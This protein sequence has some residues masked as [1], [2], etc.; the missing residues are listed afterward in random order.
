MRLSAYLM[1]IVILLIG[2]YNFWSLSFLGL[3]GN[4][5]LP[6]LIFFGAFSVLTFLVQRLL[7]SSGWRLMRAWRY[8]LAFLTSVGIGVF[9]WFFP[10]VGG[11]K[12]NHLGFLAS[13]LG[14]SFAGAMLVTALDF[15]LW[16][17]NAPPT[18]EIEEEV[19][20]GHQEL[21]GSTLPEP[22]MK[23]VFDII[24]SLIVLIACFPIWLAIIFI[25]W[26]ED[27]G[28]IIFIKNCVG[29]GGVNFLQ[30]KFR[31]MVLNAEKKTGPV[32]GTID[33]KRA[34]LTGKA[35]R[36]L[37]LDELPQVINI[38]R[39][40][41]SF[42]GPRPQRTVLVWGYLQRHPKYALRHQVRP[43][44]AGLQVVTKHC[45][46]PLQRLRLDRVYVCHMSIRFDMRILLGAFLVVLWLRWQKSWNGCLPDWLL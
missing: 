20:Q 9:F 14:G 10:Q 30:L 11:A 36:R 16:E 7:S 6:N 18:K 5:L 28:P 32:E 25:I 12:L 38:L 24:L 43:G 41:M 2:L 22:R 1:E 27:P 23:K 44:L 35:L 26:W 8:R 45:V 42:V 13:I 33:D 31:T 19:K 29:R 37:A 17:I 21:I 34:L 4:W 3:T 40:E 46:T 15:G 39:G